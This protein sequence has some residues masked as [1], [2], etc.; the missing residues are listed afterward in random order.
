[1]ICKNCW[2]QTKQRNKI[3]ISWHGRY[4]SV[5]QGFEMKRTFRFNCLT[6]QMRL[7]T[8]NCKELSCWDIS[9]DCMVHGVWAA[10]VCLCLC[11]IKLAG[12]H[13]S[14]ACEGRTH[15]N[16][17]FNIGNQAHFNIDPGFGHLFC[18][19]IHKGMES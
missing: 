5:N 19:G 2:H 17:Y 16:K 15:H 12:P 6:L 9:A 1:M 13:S 14:W 8:K 11:V 18:K 7:S 4:Q 10:V 3:V